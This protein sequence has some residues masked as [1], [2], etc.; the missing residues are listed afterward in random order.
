MKA[1]QVKDAIPVE[2]IEILPNGITCLITSCKDYDHYAT[3]PCVVNFDGKLFGKT[4]WNSDTN[5]ACYKSH[6]SVAFKV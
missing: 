1:N 6:T 3:L 5:K 2:S 4:G